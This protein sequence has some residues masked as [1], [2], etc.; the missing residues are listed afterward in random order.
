MP[1]AGRVLL[2]TGRLAEPSLRRLLEHARPPFAW[3]IAVMKITVAALMTTE[4]IGRFLTVPEGTSRVLI[5]GLCEGDTE[6]LSSRLGVH[7]ERGPEDFR[8]LP[9]SWGQP[10]RRAAY[11]AFDIE[12]VAEIN[13]VPA[14]EP[15]TVYDQAD[16]FR[17]AGADII[18][19]GCSP[20]VTFSG[21]HDLIGRLVAAG[22][23]VS[24]DSFD[25]DE[26]RTAVDAG[27]TLVLS[28]NGSNLGVLDDLTGRDVRIVAIPD[29]GG[30]LES[31]EPTINR[32]EQRRLRY[33]IDP[34]LEPIGHGFMASL[35][36]YAITRR[37]YPD[38]EM[39]MG[40]GNVTELT[41]ADTT[42][43]NAVL[44]AIC[45][46]LG[47]RTVLTTEVTPWARGAVRELDV[48]RRLM[49]YAITEQ[50]IPKRVDN[51]LVTLRDPAPLTAFTEAELRTLQ[52]TLTDSNFRIFTDAEAITVLNNTLFVRDRSAQRIFA[53]LGVTDASHAFYLGTELARAELAMH[54]GKTYKQDRQLAW[55]YMTA[56]EARPERVRL[57]GPG[58]PDR[59]D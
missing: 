4:W 7:V 6:A 58:R 8:E 43:V 27:A 49:H 10:D 55:G 2:V 14:L 24:I 41:A 57:T 1:D 31:L 52:A 44:L 5:P 36:R 38:A 53:Q 50:T 33:L 26:I 35:E 32:L 18:D 56:P 28:V 29:P 17:R 45:Q 25:R 59:Q 9:Q 30:G 21:L 46:E 22:H 54:L 51:R 11:G 42:G 48:A 19:V 3:D 20:G 12:I 39:L 40:V 16:S 34:V 13:N 47:I 37:R 15:Q 23:R